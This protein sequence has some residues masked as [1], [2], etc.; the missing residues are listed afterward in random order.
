MKNRLLG[1]PIIGLAAALLAGCGAGGFTGVYN[2]PLP[3]GADIGS[4]PYQVRVQFRDVLDLVPQSTVKVND[5][6]VGKV[7]SIELD[8]KTWTATAVI[9]VASDVRM[10]ANAAAM[11]RQSSL[12]GEKYVEL[13]QPVNEAPHGA[14]ANGA[15][16]PLSRTNRNP[17]VEEVL[18]ALSMLLNGGG[19]DQ[20]QKINTEL[21]SALSGNEPEIRGL[22]VNLNQLTANLDAQKANITRALDSVN[23]LSATL[24][25]QRNNLA[26]ALDNLG[27]GLQVLNQQR[28]QLVTML[29]SMN[30]L[31][32]VA[33]D[34]IDKSKADTIANLKDLVPVLQQLNKAGS[35]V[36]QSLQLLATY[37]FTDYAAGS[38]KGDY[39]NL[40]V[41]LDLNFSNLVD[42]LTSSKQPLIPTPGGGG[43]GGP[44]LP[45]PNIPLLP[46]L[47]TGP[48]TQGNPGLGG[49]L[50][51]LL[52]GR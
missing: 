14:L 6:A 8:Q 25:G 26:S 12:L 23:R 1:I 45:L 39:I 2:L 42:T 29:E 35:A 47:P 21:N 17:E 5:V 32:G 36:P 24:N 10:P 41:H 28:T 34:T 46:P 20:I 13:D 19:I 37:P 49:L 30:K 52:G 3:G 16:I 44:P 27:P 22:L 7:Q 33:V 31:S 15:V 38:I 40:N 9:A 4:H 18:G 43:Q 48:P 50:G 51:P 11:L